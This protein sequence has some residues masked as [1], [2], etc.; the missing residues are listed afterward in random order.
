MCSLVA[1]PST[2]HSWRHKGLLE[3]KGL[4]EKGSRQ[5]CTSSASL[6]R[7][8]ERSSSSLHQNGLEVRRDIQ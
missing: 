1:S 4:P 8:N 7:A 2:E 3:K 5:C 6:V